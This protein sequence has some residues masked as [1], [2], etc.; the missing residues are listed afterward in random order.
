MSWPERSRRVVG[1]VQET[2]W[3][4]DA[5]P[6]AMASSRPR[7]YMLCAMEEHEERRPSSSERTTYQKR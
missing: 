7:L 5:R 4:S 6:S 3:L 2:N 1:R